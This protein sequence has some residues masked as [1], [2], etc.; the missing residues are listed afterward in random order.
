MAPR[1]PPRA[2]KGGRVSARGARRDT[3]PL[4]AQQTL[5]H[6]WLKSEMYG[7][8]TTFCMFDSQCEGPGG[9]ALGAWKLGLEPRPSAYGRGVGL[10]IKSMVGLLQRACV[11]CVLCSNWVWPGFGLGSRK[12][13]PRT[14]STH[15]STCH[16]LRVSIHFPP[17]PPPP[18]LWP[19]ILALGRFA[20][21][22]REG[23][24]TQRATG[25]A[26]LA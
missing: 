14:A 13:P 20:S 25:S 8:C 21:K 17:C 12:A 16:N 9:S 3:T 19:L 5:S 15:K 7:G 22:Q 6:Q 2:A 4:F 18:P 11:M 24:R 26:L 10:Q 23:E 1:I